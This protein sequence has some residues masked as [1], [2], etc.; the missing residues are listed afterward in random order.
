MGES[1]PKDVILDTRDLSVQFGMER[2]ASR[3]LRNVDISIERNEILGVVGESGSGKSMFG[4]SLLNAVDK[5]GITT[6]EVLYHPRGGEP[7]D[8]LAQDSDELKRLRWNEISMVFQG[9]LSSFNPT[10][11]I[12]SH[13]YETLEAHNVDRDSGMEYGRQLLRDLYLEPDRVLDSHPHELSGGMR[14]RALIALSLLLNPDVLVMDEPTAALDLLMQRSILELIEDIHS[15]YNLTVVLISHDLPIVAELAD[16]L[17][18]LYAFEFVEIGPSDELIENPAH[19]YT[20]ELLET[21]PDLH[22]SLEH[23]QAIPGSAPDPI[24]EL[25]GCSFH[26]RC[27]LGD[28]LCEASDPDH[29]QVSDHHT[30][31]CHYWE[32]VSQA[33]RRK[34]SDQIG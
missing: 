4:D 10:V 1:P 27:P 2:G 31:A 6:G 3:V 23:M 12:R 28:E 30:S 21:I 24:G 5:P 20:K 8:V 9:A 11:T 25:P 33:S 7:V 29:A 15:K 19:P 13:F 32:D 14:Q 17:A 34:Q 26:P 22:S 16:R 18:V